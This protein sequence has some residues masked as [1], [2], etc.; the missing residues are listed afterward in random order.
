[1]SK[2]IQ[3]VK[4]NLALSKQRTQSLIDQANATTGNEDTDLTSAVGS[5]VSGFGQGGSGV[6]MLS[7]TFILDVNRLGIEIP[8]SKKCTNILIWCPSVDLSDLSQFSPYRNL[9]MWGKENTFINAIHVNYA[10]STISGTCKAVTGEEKVGGNQAYLFFDESC[11]K[12]NAYVSG[13]GSQL[14]VAG[15]EYHWQAW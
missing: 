1:M 6:E 10:G 9:G 13:V 12:F 11:I 4:D 5:L 14:W 15:L 8:V 7:G 3:E 2:T